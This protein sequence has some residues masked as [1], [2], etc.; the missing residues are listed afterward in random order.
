MAQQQEKATQLKPYEPN[1][2]ELWVKKLEEQF[3]T[4]SLHWH[5]FFTSAYAGG[6]FT[7]G[8]GYLTHVGSYNTI[9]FRGSWT[10]SGLSARGDGVHRAASVRPA[11]EAVGRR[12]LAQGHA[13]RLLRLRHGGDLVGRSRQLR[14]HAALRRGHARL[15][16]DARHRRA[17]RRRRVLAVGPAGRRGHASRR[18]TRSTPPSELPGLGEKVTYLHAHGTAAIDWRTSEGYIAPRRLLRR[19]VQQLQ[20]RRRRLQLQARGLRGHPARARSGA[21]PGCSRC[22]PA[23]RPR[24]PRRPTRCRSS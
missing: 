15:P 13:G 4:G 8:A 23:C 24:P 2:A 17:Q 16:A 5:P 12:R 14:V 3:L 18:W 22:T 1:K 10:P 20:R 11:R 9:D 6:G 19:H 7:L 21:T